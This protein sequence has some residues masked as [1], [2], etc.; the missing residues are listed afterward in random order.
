MYW[1]YLFEK[2]LKIVSG[3]LNTGSYIIA[4]INFTRAKPARKA[5]HSLYAVIYI[6]ITLNLNFE[7]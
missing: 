3:G 1:S 5:V 7:S 6:K 2:F 4:F